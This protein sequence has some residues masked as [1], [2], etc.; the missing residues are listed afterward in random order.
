MKFTLGARLTAEFIGTAFLVAAVVG[1]GVMGE[2]LA[3]GNVAIALLANTLAT[4][5]AL[6]ALIAAFGTISGAH[7]NPVVTLADAVGWRSSLEGCR[8]LHC[9]PNCR[10]NLRSF[11][12]APDVWTFCVFIVP[13]PS[14]WVSTR[15]ERVCCD[16]WSAFGD[17]GMFSAKT[18]NGSGRSWSVHHRGLL[19]HRIHVLRES[20]GDDRPVTLQ[21]ICWNSTG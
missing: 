2:K 3:G 11:G 10:R 6:V 1:S 14:S 12:R 7:F 20:R 8:S 4:G 15:S 9:R 13:A 18:V 17:F 16:L 19:V 21:H 5:A